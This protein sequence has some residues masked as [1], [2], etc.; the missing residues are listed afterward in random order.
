MVEKTEDRRVRK[1]Q[2]AIKEG[3]SV[4]MMKKNIKDISVR[5]L[6]EL[7]DLNRATFYLHY[8]D[9]YDLQQHVEDEI[10]GEIGA[11]LDSYLPLKPGEQPYHLFVALLRY[12]VENENQCKMLL[13]TNNSS[14]F[15]DK[16]NRIV[17]EKCVQNWLQNFRVNSDRQE[18][19]YFNAFLISG[20]IASIK[21]WLESEMKI[22]PEE[23]A[24]IMEGMAMHGIGFLQMKNSKTRYGA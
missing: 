6:T 16:M 4:L 13:S 17:N 9:I 19:E 24:H 11:M 15:W 22:K 18:M 10:I 3:F 12:I 14:S 1:T 23:L 7:A 20:Y 8:Q 5:E 2:K 21:Y